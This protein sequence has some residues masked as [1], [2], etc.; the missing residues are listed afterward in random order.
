MQFPSKPSS[1]RGLEGFEAW[2]KQRKLVPGGPVQVF[3]VFSALC[4]CDPGNVMDSIAAAKKA[5]CRISVVGLAAEVHVCRLMVNVRPVCTAPLPYISVVA[6]RP[7]RCRGAFT[8]LP[9]CTRV[10]K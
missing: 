6:M 8:Y 5:R 4:T 1:R 2:K 10:Y 7:P 9:F 3:F